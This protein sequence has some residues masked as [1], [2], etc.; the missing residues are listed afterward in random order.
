MVRIFVRSSNIAGASLQEGS[1]DFPT[2]TSASFQMCCSPLALA[3]WTPP[4]LFFQGSKGKKHGA[5]VLWFPLLI[6]YVPYLDFPCL[7]LFPLFPLFNICSRLTSCILFLLSNHWHWWKFTALSI[8]HNRAEVTS[9]MTSSWNV[10][11]FRARWGEALKPTEYF[12]L[13]P[14]YQENQRWGPEGD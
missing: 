13:A 5:S 7:F 3:D 9:E 1:S 11:C 8:H 14:L 4:V 12:I 2:F 6:F 10:S